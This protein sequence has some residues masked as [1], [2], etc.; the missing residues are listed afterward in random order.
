MSV[1]H[2]VIKVIDKFNE[3]V[4]KVVQWFVLILVLTLVYEVFMR[5]AMGAPTL[6]SY[7]VTYFSASL[8]LALGMAHTLKEG[9]H[10]NIDII[11]EKMS[12]RTRA[13]LQA[14]F[15]LLLFFPLW[16]FIIEAFLPNVIY[17]WT[18]GERARVGSWMPIIY[19]F[20]TWLFAGVVLLTLQGVSEFLKLIYMAITNEDKYVEKSALERVQE[21]IEEKEALLQEEIEEM[22]EETTEG[23][24]E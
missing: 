7:D 8:F 17:S 18:T 3:Y 1:F 19:P 2:G 5:Y 15:Y 24:K 16:Y 11:I 20:K 13:I 6:W 12:I 4:V 9:G 14:F 23:G 21:E 10:V 22:K